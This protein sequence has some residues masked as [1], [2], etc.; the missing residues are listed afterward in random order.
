MDRPLAM[1]NEAWLF[2]EPGIKGIEEQFRFYGDGDDRKLLR[3]DLFRSPQVRDQFMPP[4]VE[5]FPK[6]GSA[7]YRPC[8][9]LPNGTLHQGKPMLGIAGIGLLARFC[10]M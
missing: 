7:V 4:V 8:T 10:R 1:V 9:V 6:A 3:R 5:C 2:Q